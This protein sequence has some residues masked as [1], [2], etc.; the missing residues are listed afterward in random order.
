MKVI[1]IVGT[2]SRD[3]DE[4]FEIVEKAFLKVYQEG[5]VICSGRA[6]KG[7]DKFAV[8]L[9]NKYKTNTLWFPPDPE[10]YGGNYT[11]A[12]FARNSDIALNSDIL[13]AC[14]SPDRGLTVGKGTEDTIR[15]YLKFHKDKPELI[16]V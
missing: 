2:R 12:C 9:S 16:T 4:D 3:T 11:K 15:K 13:I 5:D 7:G 10:K 6:K 1:G 8:I 14:V